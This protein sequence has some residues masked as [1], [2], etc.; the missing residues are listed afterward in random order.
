[1]KKILIMVFILFFF[2][3]CNE[4]KQDLL[5]LSEDISIMLS[6][7]NLSNNDIEL[8]LKDNDLIIQIIFRK[9]KEDDL[10]SY[11]LDEESNSILVSMITH[12]FFNQLKN[13]ETVNYE[14]IFFDKSDRVLIDQGFSIGFTKARLNEVYSN[15]E[16]NLK[17]LEFGKYIF[18][19]IT[20]VDIVRSQA[21]I[22]IFN[23]YVDGF[24]FNGSFWD[25]LY[26]F[27]LGCDNPKE[28]LDGIYHFIAFVGL[29]KDPENPREDDIDQ[30]KFKYFLQNC[31]YP[32]D[33]IDMGLT[34]LL[35]Y[36]DERYEMNGEFVKEI[37]AKIK[38][39]SN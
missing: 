29:I 9:N 25:L 4:E 38:N 31:N 23:K 5:K 32:I 36:L 17:F 24:N 21:S 14:L 8:S 3:N 1:M 20:K 12:N 11:Y 34:S 6:N 15:I 35:T 18:K 22:E 39:N 7:W 2:T 13:Y 37:I 16:S 19:N 27:S 10:N 33:L 26:T 28:N 30:E